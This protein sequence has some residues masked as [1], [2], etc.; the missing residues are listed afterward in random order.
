MFDLLLVSITHRSMWLGPAVVDAM[1]RQFSPGKICPGKVQSCCESGCTTPRASMTVTDLT[2]TGFVPMLV[3]LHSAWSGVKTIPV[4]I[5]VACAV[6]ARIIPARA[7]HTLRDIGLLL[8]VMG[9]CRRTP[10]RGYRLQCIRSH[11]GSFPVK[12]DLKSESEAVRW[13]REGNKRPPR[14]AP[15]R[16]D[17]PPALLMLPAHH[18]GVSDVRMT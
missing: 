6:D 9:S 1:I 15:L 5:M 4:D 16:S 14:G 12:R 2:V 10:S 3:T 7:V 13:T 8:L 17:A 18:G 11:G